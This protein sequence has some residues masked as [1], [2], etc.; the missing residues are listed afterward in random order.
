MRRFAGD[1]RGSVITVFAFSAMVLAV[2]TAIV[3]NQ[4]SFYMAKRKLQ[5]AVDMA[6]LMVMESG[7]ITVAN[8]KALLETQLGQ[9]VTN[10]A[11]T[12]GR[13]SADASIAEASRFTPNAG[14][15]NAVHVSAQIPGDK[16]MLAGMMSG[17]PM[18]NANARAARRTTASV[19]IGSR[20]VR[21]EGGL[22][23]AL[24]DAA[25][26]YKGKLTVMDYES[27]ASAKVDVGQFLQAL[28]VKADIK[29]VTF[30]DVVS[31]PVSVGQILEAMIATTPSGSV[32][33]LLKKGSPASGGNKVVLNRFLDLGAITNLPI[34]GLLAGEAFPISVGEILNGSAALAD[35]DHQIAINL[36]AVLGDASIADVSLD[37]GEKPQVL[38]YKGRAN[39]GTKLSTSQFALNIG[40]LGTL[41]VDVTL[42][43]AEVEIDDIKCKADG[44]AE[45]V[46]K[47]VTEAASVGL[48][49]PILPRIG[50]KLGS[51]EEKKLTFSEAD[52]QAQT[53][54]PVRSGLGLQ[55]GSLSIAQKLLF[56]PVDSLLEKLGLHVAEADVKVTEATCGSAGL[57]H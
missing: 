44:S 51:N 46:L 29:A 31:A 39:E 21:I 42:A 15:S 43:N 38:N 53:Y 2:L 10:V 27:L 26:G 48:K 41:K 22:S 9:P 5:S 18:I 50:V 37:V 7:V 17:T 49:A 16:V 33:T 3:M 30:N 28:N 24:L 35:G 1:R 25:L 32:Q 23:A 8:A 45:V 57:V 54:K 19:V 6:A 4:I 36:G 55:L 52:I 13:Y 47:A 34:D 11:V 20:L 14:P 12:Q 40:A 56:S